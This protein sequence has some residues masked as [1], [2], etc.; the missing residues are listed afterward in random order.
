MAGRQDPALCTRILALR[1]Y[2]D[3]KDVIE[4]APDDDPRKKA[5]GETHQARIWNALMHVKQE[6]MTLE[7]AEKALE[8]AE[9]TLNEGG[10]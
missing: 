3:V 1:D 7:E 4:H 9:K 8:E 6:R 5:V 10:E 2:R